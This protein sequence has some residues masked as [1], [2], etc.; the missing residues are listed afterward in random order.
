MK[1]VIAIILVIFT[2]IPSASANQEVLITAPSYR[3]ANGVFVT[4]ELAVRLSASGDLG[5]RLFQSIAKANQVAIDIALIEEIQD[6]IDGY[7]YLDSEGKEVAVAEFPTA[8]IWLETLRRSLANK[9]VVSL[10]YGNPDS[11]FLKR[12]APVEYRFYR[13][14]AAARLSGFLGAPLGDVDSINPTDRGAGQTARVLHRTNRSELRRLYQLVPAP[15]VLSLRLELAKI[16]NPMIPAESLPIHA[17]DLREVLAENSK[18]LRVAVGNYTVTASNYD[19]PITLINDYSLPATVELR[20]QP[21]N[22]RVLVIDRERV[23]IP[24]NSQI[25]VA[26]PIQVI[27]SGDSDLRVGLFANSGKEIGKAG[28]IPLRLAVISPVTTWFTTGMA[29]ILLMAAVI[30]S[31]RRIK[32]RKS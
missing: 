28:V 26:L 19:L 10:P 25:Q 29:I 30:Q 2:S 12:T 21:D 14:I 32:N 24:A 9:E 5:G 1:R 31:I 6:L 7:T 22:S 17:K 8:T 3:T 4:D 18:K 11:V 20:A 13:E 27:A 23:T 16:L 15:E